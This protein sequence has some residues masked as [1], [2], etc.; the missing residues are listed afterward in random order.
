M[1]TDGAEGV[2]VLALQASADHRA[3][4]VWRPAS[5]WRA[6][7]SKSPLILK[8]QKA[9]LR[10]GWAQV[11]RAIAAAQDDEQVLGD[12]PLADEEAWE[13]SSAARSG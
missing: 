10:Q 11:A 12:Q 5:T 8:H 7:Q 13:W 6:Q 2:D 4:L 1:W 3:G 9:P